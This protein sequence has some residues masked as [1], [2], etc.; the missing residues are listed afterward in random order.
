MTASNAS[1]LFFLKIAIVRF[2]EYTGKSNGNRLE[3]DLYEKL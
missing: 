2:L 1:K 3:K